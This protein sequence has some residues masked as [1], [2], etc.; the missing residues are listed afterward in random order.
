MATELQTI[1]TVREI[2]IRTVEEEL[3]EVARMLDEGWDLVSWQPV[4]KPPDNGGDSVFASRATKY[5]AF[6]LRRTVPDA[7]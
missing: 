6:L 3:A 7:D 1:W 5:D 4:A 2:G